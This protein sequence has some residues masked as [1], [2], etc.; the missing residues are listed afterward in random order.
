MKKA[1]KANLVS[2]KDGKGQFQL[3]VKQR[4]SKIYL[5]SK[6]DTKSSEAMPPRM[7][8]IKEV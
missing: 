6:L 5:Q 2:Q 3:L 1:Q 7:S 8:P 4:H